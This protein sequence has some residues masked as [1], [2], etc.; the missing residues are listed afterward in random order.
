MANK[1]LIQVDDNYHYGNEDE[2]YTA[3]S[4][5][6]LEEALKKCQE[7]TLSS[8]KEFYQEGISADELKAQWSM[9]G[10]DPFIVGPVEGVPFSAREFITPELCEKIIE[11]CQRK[12]L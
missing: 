3:G 12:N 7:I 4:F 8:L 1:Y 10:E 9:F 6:T 11:E 5:N 2:R